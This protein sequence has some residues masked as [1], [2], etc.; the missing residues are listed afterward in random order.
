MKFTGSNDLNYLQKRI[1]FHYPVHYDPHDVDPYCY[2]QDYVSFFTG[3]R[4]E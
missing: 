2:I 3:N 4:D 1:K